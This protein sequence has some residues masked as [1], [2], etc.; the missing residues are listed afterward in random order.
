MTK[1]FFYVCAGLFLLVLGYHLV[2]RNAEG[3]AG[4]VLV[5]LVW[6]QADGR[7]YAIDSDGGLWSGPGFCGPLER[8]GQLPPGLV[9]VAFLDGDVG[10]SVDVGCSNG[11][12]YTLTGSHPNV[13][14][15]FCVNVFG[16]AN[17]TP[18]QGKSWGQ[19]KDRYRK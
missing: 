2:A 11:D 6:R 13:G 10:G 15:V 12:V 16:I 17:P 9:P 8:S 18:T 19:V 4:Q 7:A 1:R 3:Q 5:D 14:L